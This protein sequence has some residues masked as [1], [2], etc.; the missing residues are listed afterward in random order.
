M[1]AAARAEMPRRTHLAPA[2]VFH[3]VTEYKR[4]LRGFPRW[5]VVVFHALRKINRIASTKLG[6]PVVIRYD[7]EGAFWTETAGGF[8]D[9]EIAYPA[10]SSRRDQY[11]AM[12]WDDVQIELTKN[13]PMNGFLPLTTG[14]FCPQDYVGEYIPEFVQEHTSIAMCPYKKQLCA[15]NDTMSRV[16]FKELDEASLSLDLVLNR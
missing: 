14:R 16:D 4:K 10:I 11:A 2:G 15:P 6:I 13:V 5:K 3:L 1:Q 7:G 9:L 12:G 8:T